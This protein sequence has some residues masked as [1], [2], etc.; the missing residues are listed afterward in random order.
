MLFPKENKQ[1]PNTKFIN[2]KKTK[3]NVNKT[4]KKTSKKTTK[5]NTVKRNNAKMNGGMSSIFDEGVPSSPVRFFSNLEF[6]NLYEKEEGRMRSAWE[7]L[8]VVEPTSSSLNDTSSSSSWN[9]HSYADIRDRVQNKLATKSD[10]VDIRFIYKNW[11]EEWNIANVDFIVNEI[12]TL[13]NKTH[14]SKS[15]R[16]STRRKN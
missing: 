7:T 10:M 16:N 14:K 5:K 15:K 2:Q 4:T 3:Q 1:R 9:I 8:G 6:N 11:K 12:T 13:W